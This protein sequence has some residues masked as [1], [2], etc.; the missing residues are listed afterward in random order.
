M[1]ENAGP[2]LFSALAASANGAAAAIRAQ[3]KR[4]EVDFET[5]SG[6][7]KVVDGLLKELNESQAD[8]KKL[9]HGTLPK[10]ALG[11]GFAEAEALFTTYQTVQTQL[12]N[13]SKGL[14]AQIEG[15]G[16]AIQTSGKGFGEIDEEQRRRMAMIAK[17]AKHDYNPDL[18]PLVQQQKKDEANK[19]KGKI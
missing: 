3:A 15:L 6:Y 9:A 14:A 11:K 5:L 4:F 13:L 18:D 8:D 17:Q 1:A 10:G 7:K 2:D 12:E 19:P 16:I